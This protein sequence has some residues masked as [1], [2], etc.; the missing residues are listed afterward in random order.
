MNPAPGYEPTSTTTRTAGHHSHPVITA[1]QTRADLGWK[2][3]HLNQGRSQDVEANRVYAYNPTSGTTGTV[4]HPRRD[5]IRAT[6]QSP[7]RHRYRRSAVQSCTKESAAR[8]ASLT[9]P[10]HCRG[11]DRRPVAPCASSSRRRDCHD[12]WTTPLRACA[13]RMPR[14]DRPRPP[15][16]RRS[17]AAFS[18]TET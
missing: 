13:I 5:T 2:C 14:A 16:A 10:G 1:T 9:D 4:R 12:C 11:V 17:S 3:S 18:S 8:C 15:D 6:H 7:T